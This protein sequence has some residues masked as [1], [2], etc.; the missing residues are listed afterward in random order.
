MNMLLYLIGIFVVIYIF[1]ALLPVLLPLIIILA[2]LSI[3]FVW[4]LKRKIKKHMGQYEHDGKGYSTGVE[5]DTYTT[6][7][8]NNKQT[9]QDQDI[10]DVE[11]TET[12]QSDHL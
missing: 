10:I 1:F 2:I 9:S 11:F 4:Y 6:Y 5:D 8:S 12:D 3:T 7:S